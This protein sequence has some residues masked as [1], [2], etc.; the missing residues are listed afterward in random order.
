GGRDAA[1]Q[2]VDLLTALQEAAE[3]AL[4]LFLRLQH[5]V[6]VV[7][8]QRLQ[9]GVLYA[10]IVGDL[11]VIQDGPGERWP[12]RELDS[13]GAEHFVDPVLT[14]TTGHRAKGATEREGREQI[15]FGHADLRAL[16][17]GLE[18]GAAD[19]GAPADQVRRY[20][21]RDIPRRHRDRLRAG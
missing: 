7:D 21:D 6:L 9:A 3:T 16:G 5:R 4:D 2:Q 1:P 17:G 20:A 18:F 11:A 19:I 14:G 12:E 15:G 8:Q 13:A 10:N